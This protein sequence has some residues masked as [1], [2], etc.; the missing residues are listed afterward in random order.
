[1]Q[2]NFVLTLTWFDNKY[3][4]DNKDK[5]MNLF[6]FIVLC[7]RGL[8]TLFKK[9]CLWIAQLFRLAVRYYWV[10]IICLISGVFVAWLWTRPSLTRYNGSVTV[11]FPEGMK[12]SVE[13]GFFKFL[14]MD[15]DI[16]HD[17]YGL[18]YET[19]SVMKK[20]RLYNVI[21]A[22][23]DSV[24]DYVDRDHE[25][26]VN[27]TMDVVMTDRLHVT[28]TMFGKDDFSSLE[29]ALKKFFN[30]EELLVA[31]YKRFKDKQVRLLDYF[32]REAARVDSFSTYDYFE[33]PRYFSTERFGNHLITERQV[34]LHYLDLQYLE[35][36]LAYMKEQYDATP[37]VINF[38]TPIIVTFMLPVKKYCIC[39]FCGV[40]LGLIISCIIKYRV[41]IVAFLKEE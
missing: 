25:I 28:F 10:M 40:L 20:M 30:S 11:R 27:D 38:Q 21:D 8:C 37:E 32:T 39:V 33:K 15:S 22:K 4:T 9:I 2:S 41:R 26:A 14:T 24:A 1:M 23:H 12:N 18:D 3:M 19:M 16:K 31:N 34:E 29:C 35:N 7:C 5:E 6:D 13:Q 17:V 36:R